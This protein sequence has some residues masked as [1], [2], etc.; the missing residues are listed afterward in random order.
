MFSIVR[1]NLRFKLLLALF[2]VLVVSFFS[3]SF[4]I[5]TIQAS[6]QKKMGEKVN[7]ALEKT[8]SDARENFNKI[9]VEVDTLLKGMRLKASEAIS[10]ST[11]I[12]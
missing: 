11:K 6:R 10:L 2:V 1:R 8:G 9:K 12:P 3:L 5:V 7:I 4:S